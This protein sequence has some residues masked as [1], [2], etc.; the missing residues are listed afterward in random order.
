L[1]DGAE[2]EAVD[3]NLDQVV[4]DIDDVPARMQEG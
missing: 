4:E 2:V 1:N 3:A